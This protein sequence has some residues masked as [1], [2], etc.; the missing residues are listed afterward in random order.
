MLEIT[1]DK[2]SCHRHL[3]IWTIGAL[4][5]CGALAGKAISDVHRCKS[6]NSFGMRQG[7]GALGSPDS[8][9]VGYLAP[10]C[11]RLRMLSFFTPRLI[12]FINICL[13]DGALLLPGMWHFGRTCFY[14]SM[15]LL[16]RMS[17]RPPLSNL[18]KAG[19]CNE[20]HEEK[21]SIL[22]FY[23]YCRIQIKLLWKD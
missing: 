18:S 1:H 15:D 12:S 21:K 4:L 19:T 6:N 14:I 8:Y 3:W 13:F 2:T 5:C 11:L 7:V 20:K 10:L 16:H 9:T 17:S 22:P 23:Y